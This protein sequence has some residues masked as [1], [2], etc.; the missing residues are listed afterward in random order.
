M[1]GGAARRRRPAAR[2]ARPAA[3]RRS[4]STR[5]ARAAHRRRHGLAGRWPAA[6][7]GRRPTPADGRDARCRSTTAPCSCSSA[8]RSPPTTS[9]VL[10]RVRRPARPSPSSSRR[11]AGRGGRAPRR[12]P[13]PTSCAPRSSQAVSP[14]PAHAAGVDQGVGHEPA[15]A[16]RRL[17]ADEPRTSSST[18]IDEETDRLNRL[19]GNLLDMSRL[20]G[21]R[22]A[23]STLR[24]V[25][26]EE[27]VAARPGQP[28]PTEP[29]GSTST[30]PRRCRRSHADPALLERAVANLV[31]NAAALRPAGRAGARRGRR[32]RR[33][34]RPAG[35]RP[36][37]RHPA[38]RP[39]ARS[40]SR[41][42]GS[43]TAPS[44]AGVGLG[45]AVARGFVEAMGGELDASRTPRAAALHRW[46][47]A[48]GAADGRRTVVG[49]T[50]VLVVDDEP[51]IRRALAI[52]PAG[53]RLRGRPGRRRARR[54][55]ALAADAPPRRGRSSTS[56]CPASTASR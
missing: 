18:T 22:A 47:L 31:A 26:L 11:A 21:R 43:A 16:R 27:V 23:T 50:G 32:G 2:A 42:S 41:S 3:R 6:G 38:G 54:R 14:R 33:P 29:T 10:E 56:G 8:R 9:R 15:A 48:A 20:A 40:S 24:P 51:Q 53:P 12:W 34:G 13:R 19:V 55:C 46:S 4:G 37:P 45:L 28:R 49:M 52:E 7:A 17:D 1:A 36:R 5:V 30:C 44:G 35:R 25:G 39:R